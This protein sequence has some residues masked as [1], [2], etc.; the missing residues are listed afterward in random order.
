MPG[1]LIDWVLMA[2][3]FALGVALLK[4]GRELE[5]AIDV[6]INGAIF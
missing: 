1:D 5:F 6:F 2:S 3:V 4:Y